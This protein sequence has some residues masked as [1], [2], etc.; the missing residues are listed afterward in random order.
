MKITISVFEEKYWNILELRLLTISFQLI[1]TE[2]NLFD[3][4]EYLYNR[5]IRCIYY[6][7]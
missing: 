2:F 1:E 7:Q 3:S 6:I 4:H 5:N